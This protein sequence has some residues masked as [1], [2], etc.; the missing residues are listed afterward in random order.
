MGEGHFIDD[1]EELD[2]DKD[3][4]KQGD[5][6]AP[7][8]DDDPDNQDD[9]FRVFYERGGRKDSI[10]DSNSSKKEDGDDYDHEAFLEQMMVDLRKTAEDMTEAEIKR[11]REE[12]EAAFY[13][14][15]DMEE[16]KY[17]DNNF[18]A[19]PT[20]TTENDVDAL[21]AELDDDEYA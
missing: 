8:G 6:P 2:S 13:K 16:S 14:Q 5:A 15:K 11:Q 7:D 21:L 10:A 19:I 4:K 3:E 20:K 17:S 12:K 9:L 18:W 1:E